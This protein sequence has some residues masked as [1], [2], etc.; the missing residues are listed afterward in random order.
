MAALI[1]RSGA[2]QVDWV[3]TSM[4]GLIGTF[5][6]ATRGAPIRRM[7]VNDVGPFIP[8]AAL[9][10]IAAYVGSEPRFADLAEAEAYL[11]RVHA[12]FGPLSDGQWRHLSTH[13]TRPLPDGGFGLAYDPGIAE[14]FRG[15]V[16]DVDLWPVWQQVGSEVLVVRGA[17]SDLLDPSTARRMVEVLGARARLVEFAGI[18]HAPAFMAEDQIGAVESFLFP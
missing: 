3:G 15:G 7:V 9:E 10:R 5:L 6:A 4:G 18:G 16:A 17:E 2:H 11:R 12:P 14:A 8:Q 1:A 13:G